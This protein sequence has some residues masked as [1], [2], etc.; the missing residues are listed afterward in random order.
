[1][2]RPS[3]V[4]G[5]RWFEYEC[6]PR[7]SSSNL[8][9]KAAAV[10]SHFMLSWPMTS[11]SAHSYLLDRGNL[12]GTRLKSHLRLGIM[13]LMPRVASVLVAGGRWVLPHVSQRRG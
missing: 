4:I 12:L 6:G 5:L 1:M 9:F 13:W 2:V 3:L 10:L 8:P 11:R 7:S